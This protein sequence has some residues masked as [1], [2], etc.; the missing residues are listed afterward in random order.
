MKKLITKSHS[1]IQLLFLLIFASIFLSLAIRP[2]LATD[3]IDNFD[4]SSLNTSVWTASGD[5]NYSLTDNPGNLRIYFAGINGNQRIFYFFPGRQWVLEIKVHYNMNPL[6]S[7]LGTPSPGQ[8][9]GQGSAITYVTAGGKGFDLAAR[10]LNGYTDTIIPNGLGWST[11]RWNSNLQ[12]WEYVYGLYSGNDGTH[13][14]RFIRDDNTL[15]MYHSLDNIHWDQSYTETVTIVS[16]DDQNGINLATGFNAI[17]PFSGI[18][19]VEYDYV[20]ISGISSITIAIDPG[21]G[22]IP[23]T[24]TYRGAPPSIYNDHEDDLNLDM[25]LGVRS[26]LQ[27]DGYNSVMTRTTAFDLAKG[28]LQ[29]NLNRCKIANNSKPRPKIFVSIHCNSAADYKGNILPDRNGTYNIYRKEPTTRG[30]ESF[31]LA[32]LVHM[33]LKSILNTYPIG[34]SGVEQ[35]KKDFTVLKNTK[36][37]AIIVETCF[38][39]N[40]ELQSNQIIT[41]AERLHFYY[42]R[43]AI[44][45]TICDGVKDFIPLP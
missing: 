14:F 16:L 21:H 25:G 33:R 8:D 28:K 17:T 9:F 43:Q 39:S 18:A 22:L 15:S 34:N 45:D 12:Q 1:K 13:Y 32:T 41:D 30:I 29:A 10:L 31:K 27:N 23:K 44:M 24:S 20:K 42:R 6:A 4:S 40:S 36:M 2:C 37:P 5:L 38:I 19:Y 3:F 35:D 26:N 11:L 7:Y